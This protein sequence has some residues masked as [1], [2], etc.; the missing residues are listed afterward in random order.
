VD[1]DSRIRFGYPHDRKSVR[2][3]K[4]PEG[5]L[6]IR[7]WD[8]VTST[9]EGLA[10]VRNLERRY[11]PIQDYQFLRDPDHVE[12]FVPYFWVT[13]KDPSA[14]DHLPTQPFVIQMRVP[15]FDRTRPGGVSLSDLR[16]YIL[17]EEKTE[18][19]VSPPGVMERLAA[20]GEGGGSSESAQRATRVIDVRIERSSS[21]L[22]CKLG[23]DFAGTGRSRVFSIG[24]AFTAWGG[25]YHPE[26]TT[27]IQT[28]PPEAQADAE[29]EAQPA[30][31]VPFSY[32]AQAQSTWSSR[33]QDIDSYNAT[34]SGQSGEAVGVVAEEPV[35]AEAPVVE[36]D[37]I[38]ETNEPQSLSPPP[39]PSVDLPLET[40]A[41][42]VSSPSPTAASPM[43]TK[44]KS[45]PSPPKP[46]SPSKK[47]QMLARARELA[48]ASYPT[49]IATEVAEQRAEKDEEKVKQAAQER[50]QYE[51]DH[52]LDTVKGRLQKIMGGRWY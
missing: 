14:V 46:K 3:Y 8:G 16:D 20:E 11:G 22:G 49:K 1:L 41:T 4:P 2:R 48:R 25:F 24:K 42:D 27:D 7:P 15:K 12:V 44:A 21:K 31:Q 13:F 40:E 36:G 45:S 30:P 5:T 52:F 43:E 28:P 35:A 18:D 34:A 6:F 51:A 19:S 17:P 26:H 37:G 47:E 10:V 32:M 50:E 23:E 29:S 38:H 9:V 33:F 39:L